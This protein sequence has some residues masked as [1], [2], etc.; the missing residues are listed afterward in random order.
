VI[1]G[2]KELRWKTTARKRASIPWY[3]CSSRTNLFWYNPLLC[4]EVLVERPYFRSGKEP[5]KLNSNVEL[6]ND[7]ATRIK[8]AG[9]LS[10]RK[11]RLRSAQIRIHLPSAAAWIGS[12]LVRP[13]IKSVGVGTTVA[14]EKIHIQ[15]LWDA[16][17]KL[18]YHVKQYWRLTLETNVSRSAILHI[19][20]QENP[21]PMRSTRDIEALVR[22]IIFSI[23]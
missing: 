10:R 16:T 7:P 12:L 2:T 3:W 19:H 23:C 21:G 18:L 1:K 6:E 13:P 11:C 9:F 8:G 20:I 15:S 4:H 17:Y 22:D 14:F 5:L